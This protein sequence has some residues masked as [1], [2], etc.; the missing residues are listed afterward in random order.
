[1]RVMLC[2]VGD[3]RGPQIGVAVTQVGPGSMV[4]LWG[5]AK[6][7]NC[8]GQTIKLLEEARALEEAK[9]TAQRSGES[10]QG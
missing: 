10:E 8:E 3:L 5:E 1:V 2:E 7:H 6:G 9:D 4:A